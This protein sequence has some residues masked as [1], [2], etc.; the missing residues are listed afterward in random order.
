MIVRDGAPLA[1]APDEEIE[2]RMEG[3]L[4][5]AKRYDARAELAQLIDAAEHFAGGHRRRRL[6]VLVTVSAIE[7]AATDRDHLHQERVVG[8]DHRAS[9]HAGLAPATMQ[10]D[11]SAHRL[12][13]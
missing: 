3:R 9:E 4:A 13:C 7:V 11:Q 12:S 6:V 10:S 8:G 2:I 1:H 5:A